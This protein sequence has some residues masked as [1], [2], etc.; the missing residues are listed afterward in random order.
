MGKKEKLIEK[1]RTL[2]CELNEMLKIIKAKDEKIKIV[3]SLMDENHYQFYRN[4]VCVLVQVVPKMEE[5]Y[6]E[7]QKMSNQTDK[8]SQI[9]LG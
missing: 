8:I 7:I 2:S 1:S 6:Q 9:Y 5:L 3:F 4:V